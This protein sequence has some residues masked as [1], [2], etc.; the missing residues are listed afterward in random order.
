MRAGA[1][2]LIGQM[3]ISTAVEW[4]WNWEACSLV[5]QDKAMVYQVL[6]LSNELYCRWQVPF[7][8]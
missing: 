8:F 6:L 2:M 7:M 3:S 4:G 5:L 1:N